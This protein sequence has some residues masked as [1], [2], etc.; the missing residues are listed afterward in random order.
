[1]ET[2]QS[3]NQV[4][5]PIDGQSQDD[6]KMATQGTLSQRAEPIDAAAEYRPLVLQ[7]P[8]QQ[9]SN[10][11]LRDDASQNEMMKYRQSQSSQN[12]A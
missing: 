8:G 11:Q 3:F 2:K 7:Q 5:S 10:A 6:S 1:M 9:N 4:K 12:V